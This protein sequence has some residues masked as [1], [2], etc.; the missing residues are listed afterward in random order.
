MINPQDLTKLLENKAIGWALDKHTYISQSG[1]DRSDAAEHL[2]KVK[3]SSEEYIDPDLLKKVNTSRIAKVLFAFLSGKYP[4]VE[5]KFPD[6]DFF[7][8]ILCVP[9]SDIDRDFQP[10]YEIGKKLSEYSEISLL[11]DDVFRKIKKT[12]TMKNKKKSEVEKLL[13]NAFFVEKPTELK[14]KNVLIF[15]DII[16]T[17]AT[18]LEI[19]NTLKMNAEIGDIYVLTITKTRTKTGLANQSLDLDLAF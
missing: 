13:N 18:L 14:K 11:G 19:I 15:D 1:Y 16:R 3:Y 5:K 8:Y 17:G 2:Y 10:V 6:L 9:P 12:D 7:D 4:E